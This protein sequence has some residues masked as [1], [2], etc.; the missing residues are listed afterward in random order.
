MILRNFLPLSATTLDV[1]LAPRAGFPPRSLLPRIAAL[2]PGCVMNAATDSRLDARALLAHLPLFQELPP[3]RLAAV[4]EHARLKR[5]QKGD[6]LFQKGDAALGFYLVAYGQIK[7]AFPA[8]NGNEK[9]V[10]VLGPHQ[11]FGETEMLAQ[12][13]YPVF[14]QALS[15]TLLLFIPRDSALELIEHEPVFARR[16]LVG[17]ARHTHALIQDIEAYTLHSSTERVIRH[18][19]HYCPP[20]SCGQQT[21]TLPN[22][23]QIIASRLNLTPETFSR[24]LHDLAAAQLIAIEGRRIVIVSCERLR[25]QL[26]LSPAA[27]R[28]AAAYPA[29]RRP[30]ERS[31]RAS[32]LPA[33]LEARLAARRP[34]PQ[35]PHALTSW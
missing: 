5:L 29:R 22:S 35:R 21:I 6:M 20:G 7:R 33:P 25:A 31:A 26:D 28:A 11:S 17:L 12:Q 18:L 14:A 19:L 24:I 10:D 9:I 34:V 23:K 13:P 15:D 27:P 3:A 4:A 1:V 30:A 8:S 2:V 16:L 32:P